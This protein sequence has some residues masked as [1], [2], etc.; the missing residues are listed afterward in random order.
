VSNSAISLWHLLDIIFFGV[1]Q[2]RVDLPQSFPIFFS[3]V[4]PHYFLIEKLDRKV[5]DQKQLQITPEFEALIASHREA[6]LQKMATRS[7][8]QAFLPKAFC[9]RLAFCCSI[10]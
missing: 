5:L 8:H 9:S 6:E 3:F 7:L 2:Y 1:K 10:S 4:T